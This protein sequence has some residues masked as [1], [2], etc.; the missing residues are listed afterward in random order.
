MVV[1][2]E[3]SASVFMIPD[4]GSS[5]FIIWH[6]SAEVLAVTEQKAAILDISLH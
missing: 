4:A 5:I 1:V 2:E 6:L 3:R